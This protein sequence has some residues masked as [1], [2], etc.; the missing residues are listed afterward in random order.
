L[1]DGLSPK[2]SPVAFEIRASKVT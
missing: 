2:T 1:T